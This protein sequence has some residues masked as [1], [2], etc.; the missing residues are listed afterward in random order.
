MR[1]T[2]LASLGLLGLPLGS[3]ATIP[4]QVSNEVLDNGT[5]EVTFEDWVATVPEE[6]KKFHES[7]L[8]KLYDVSYGRVTIDARDLTKRVAMFKGKSYNVSGWVFSIS[9]YLIEHWQGTSW[10][11][12][13]DTDFL[14]QNAIGDNFATNVRGVQGTVI[15]GR[16]FGGGWSWRGHVN[17]GYHFDNIPYSVLYHTCIDAIQGAVDWISVENSVTWQMLD[18]V[19]REIAMFVVYPTSYDHG[20]TPNNIHEEL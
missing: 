13:Q 5:V 4:S 14:G 3:A 9:Y 15:E 18:S 6:F 1:P 20:A 17:N 11:F 16:A 8:Q 2:Y 19:G 12:P 10:V 7:S